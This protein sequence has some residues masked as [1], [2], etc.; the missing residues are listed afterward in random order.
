MADLDVREKG[1]Y[2][3]WILRYMRYLFLVVQTQTMAA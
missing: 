2:T 1:L 3:A